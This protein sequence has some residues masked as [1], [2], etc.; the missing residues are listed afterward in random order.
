MLN[1]YSL[2]LFLFRCGRMSAG[3]YFKALV[4]YIL[5]LTAFGEKS[6]NCN[7]L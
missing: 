7:L 2:L 5:V 1:I 4:S 3:Q 6:L